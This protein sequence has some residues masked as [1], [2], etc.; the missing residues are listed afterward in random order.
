[1]GLLDFLYKDKDGN[2]IEYLMSMNKMK[3]NAKDIAIE[4]AAGMIAKTIAK[5]EFKTYNTKGNSK[6]SI[7]TIAEDYYTLNIRPNLNESATNFWYRVIMKFLTDPDGAVVIHEG[8][9]LYLADTF[10]LNDSVNFAKSITNVNVGTL[11]YD[12]PFS[13]NDVLYLKLGDGRIIKHLNSL[14]IGVLI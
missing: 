14:K 9:S 12:K 8:N 5:C 13:M 6:K 4:K 11:K 7:E 2:L 10:T 1:M 3:I